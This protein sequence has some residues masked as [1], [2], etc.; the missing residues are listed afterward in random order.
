LDLVVAVAGVVLLV[1]AARRCVGPALSVIG[2]VFIFYMFAGPILPDMIS[3]KGASI[4]RAMNQLWLTTEGV[5]GVALGV[6]TSLV[7]LFV[8]F[9]SLLEKA[10][11]GN[12]FIQV[13]YSLLGHLRGGP[14]KAGVVSSGLTGLI[15]GSSIANVVTTGTFTI[16]L[17][18]RVGYSAVKAGAIESA[19]GVNGQIMPP[20][21]G[22]AAFLIAEY[23]GI[24]YAQVVKHAFLPA[25]ITY[26]ALFYIVDIEAVKL[27]LKG[28]PRVWRNGRSMAALRFLLTFS[29]F[30]ILS[31]IVY[32]GI[33]WLRDVLGDLAMPVIVVGLGAAY[34]G[35]IAR[36][37]RFPDLALDDPE[38]P[39]LELPDFSVTARTGLHYLLP[40]FLLIWCLMIEMLSP[41]LSAFWGTVFLVVILLTQH[42]LK[43]FFRR[44]NPIGELR[45]GWTDLVEGL[46]AGGR[47]MI[48][49]GVATAAAGIVVGV[50]S[51]TG[52]GLRLTEL[53]DL[54]SGGDVIVMLSLTAV[55]CLILGMGMP[56][57]ASYVIVATLM[58]PVIVEL[59]A[60][61]DL[62]V[63]LVAVH[64]FVFYFGLMADVTPPVGLAAYAAAA[65]AGADPVRTGFQAFKYEIRTGLL[66]FIF[67]F[68]NELILIG[69]NSIWHFF[70]VLASSLSAML[71][72]VAATQNHFLTRNRLWEGAALLLVCFTLFRP[73]FWMDHLVAPFD[74][75]PPSEL[76]AIVTALPADEFLRLKLRGENAS[77]KDVEKTVKLPLPAGTSP[78]DRL[79]KVGLRFEQQ[80]GK[81]VVA[82]V[83]F[84]SQADKLGVDVDWVVQA[85]QQ[86]ASQP[87][88]ELM[89][90][91]ALA[92][93][94]LVVLSQLLRRRRQAVLA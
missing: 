37:A 90:L 35:L 31:G 7:F 24:P 65:I 56:T 42:P 14:A 2:L 60:E 63:P 29:G 85:V 72:F 81:T 40:V 15:S 86:R 73:G 45:R 55:I 54:L 58:A 27:G 83:R 43:A 77:G 70:L 11:A 68:N 62:A 93:L 17:M 50:V 94:G 59:A 64:L 87:P 82:D 51:Q 46:S 36:A 6:S 25:I 78:Q 69:V 66:P 47:N 34:I 22:A 23:V 33:G 30:V 79:N 13:A 71:L 19:A 28:T 48:G 92:L 61:N 57:T 49:V 41:A 76:N 52:V 67:I 91:P 39:N 3:H 9:G 16:P 74:D 1:E 20:V 44:Q 5:F 10:G 75:R 38:A 53:V 12:W 18:K 88:K 21:M 89:Y 80:D 32:Y 84:R 4:T 8:L 26:I